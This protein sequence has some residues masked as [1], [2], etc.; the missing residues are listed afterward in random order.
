MKKEK[1][2]KI[3]GSEIKSLPFLFP[4]R[5]HKISYYRKY[6]ILFCIL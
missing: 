3:Q 2:K 6:V 4:Y 1:S 5:I